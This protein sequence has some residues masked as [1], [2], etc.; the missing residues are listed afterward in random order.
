M[1]S[2]LILG[3]RGF[4]GQNLYSY[5]KKKDKKLKLF[6]DKKRVDLS[7]SKNWKIYPKT[8]FLVLLSAKS[9][10]RVFDKDSTLG[11]VTNLNIT[12]NAI[13]YCLQNNAK[14]IFI[15]SAS[16]KLL[17][18]D[19]AISK[20]I[21]E[22]ICENYSVSFKLKYNILRI[23]NVYGKDQSN[24]FLIPKIFNAIKKNKKIKVNNLIAKRD[25]IHIDDVCE[26]IHKSIYIKQNKI[27][28]DIGTGKSYSVRQVIS[29]ISKYLNKKILNKIENKNIIKEDEILDSKAQLSN[30]KKY[31]KWESKYSL[32]KGIKK[33]NE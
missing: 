18:N 26:A 8:D 24:L 22:R 33:I 2:V 25:Y 17:N 11:Y 32:L 9:N 7:V 14:L 15:S 29:T 10:F 23:Y 30:T 27:T 31:L 16:V 28:I 6:N 4:I 20:F 3:S 13:H 1:K 5:L 21:S 19:Y 12:L